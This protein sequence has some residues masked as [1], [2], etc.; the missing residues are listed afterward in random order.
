VNDVFLSEM[1]DMI[2]KMIAAAMVVAM[3]ATALSQTSD[4]SKKLIEKYPA[5]DR[6]K[7]GALSDQELLDLKKSVRKSGGVAAPEKSAPAGAS[8]TR[9]TKEQKAQKRLA[10]LRVPITFTDV[11]YGPLERNRLDF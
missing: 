2:R 5:A 1:R 11:A 6:D 3:C 9:P 8:T 10:K 4:K 7:D